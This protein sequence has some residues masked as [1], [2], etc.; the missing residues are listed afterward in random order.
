[1]FLLMFFPFFFQRK[2]AT[3]DTFI[4]TVFLVSTGF[5]LVALVCS[6]YI[7]ISLKGKRMQDIAKIGKAQEEEQAREDRF[8]GLFLYD[9]GGQFS[10]I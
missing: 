3:R 10:S 6:I 2:Q 4:G 5:S 7:T 9:T 8:K 1:M